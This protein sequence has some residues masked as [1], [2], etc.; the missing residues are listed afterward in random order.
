MLVTLNDI[1]PAAQAGHYAVGLFNTTDSDMLEAAI[2]AAEETRSPIVIGTA[3]ILLPYGELS[4][5]APS[6]IAA[7]KRAS[8]PV[9]V[10]YD[11]GLTF[12]RCMEALKLGFSSIMFDG[13]A[14]DEKE[15]LIATR[16]IVKI[17]H[18]FGA[19]VEGEIGHVGNAD[20]GDGET[21]DMYT[22]PEEA[23]SFVKAT[24][25]DALA[26]AIGTAHGAYKTKPQLD[27]NRLAN[28]HAAIDT[29]LV[30]HGGS[31]LSDDDFRNTIA[32]GIAKVNIF[33]DLCVA[34]YDSVKSFEG[35][36]L[37]MRNAKVK[38]M[39][40]AVINKMILFGCAGK[41]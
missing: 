39:K 11:H 17:A 29:P 6:V 4:L 31:G 40:E 9:V 20:V 1:L 33:T 3:E 7:A 22:S 2:S 15:N 21:D 5:I 18:S 24:G 16:E 23:I 28:I 35:S 41:A 32:N 13:S 36:Y 34:G 19:S 37:E 30:L 12:D 14:G 38:A 25:V 26:V 10:H 27:I 8:V